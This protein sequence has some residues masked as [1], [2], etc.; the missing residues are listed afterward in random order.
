[1]F[2]SANHSSS[3]GN[4]Q[5]VHNGITTWVEVILFL[6]FFRHF[7]STF[8]SLVEPILIYLTEFL[9]S[10]NFLKRQRWISIAPFYRH[11]IECREYLKIQDGVSKTTEVIIGWNISCCT[12]SRGISTRANKLILPY[13]VL[14]ERESNTQNITVSSVKIIF[15]NTVFK[16]TTDY[17]CSRT[18]KRCSE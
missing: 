10:S 12:E 13:W 3:G 8:D 4:R 14:L 1:M 2:V 7:H 6:Y 16:K 5:P 18:R 17:F 11:W 9:V 15:S